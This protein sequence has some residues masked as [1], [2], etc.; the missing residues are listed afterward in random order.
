MSQGWPGEPT[1]SMPQIRM[2]FC[3]PTARLASRRLFPSEARWSRCAF[4]S[5]ERWALGQGDPIENSVKPPAATAVTA[6]P[7]QPDLQGAR[8]A[9]RNRPASA[10]ATRQTTGG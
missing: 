5:G 3:H 1:L 6:A 9:Q 7:R 8:L 10:G 4:A 2:G